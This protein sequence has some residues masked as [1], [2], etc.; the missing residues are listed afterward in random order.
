MRPDLLSAAFLLVMGAALGC[1]WTAF[2]TRK[3][4]PVHKRWGIAGAAVDLLGTAAVFV[5]S[6][7]LGW[8]VP[9]R[10]ASV[11]EVHRAFAWVATALV[12]AVAGTGIARARIHTRLWVVF[13]P[14]YTAT[15]ALAVLGYAPW[16]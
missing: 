9:P 2:F 6:R 13:L 10:D 4:T 7:A 8:K 1:F 16:L 11:A 14:V 3:N 12:L 15:Y 5:T